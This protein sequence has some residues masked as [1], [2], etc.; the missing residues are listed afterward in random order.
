MKL[1]NIHNS[2]I[3]DIVGGFD[4]LHRRQ[5]MLGD[6]V[7]F[8]CVCVLVISFSIFYKVIFNGS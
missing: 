5:T 7:V 6:F 4:R 8:S 3:S 2:I 1:D